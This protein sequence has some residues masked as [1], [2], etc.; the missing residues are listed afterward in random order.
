VVE[1]DPR[2][3]AVRPLD[4]VELL[5]LFLGEH[6][7]IGLLVILG[8]QVLALAALPGARSRSGSSGGGGGGEAGAD[9]FGG[10]GPVLALLRHRHASERRLELAQLGAAQLGASPQVVPRHLRACRRKLVQDAVGERSAAENGEGHY[11]RLELLR[12]SVADA[13]AGIIAASRDGRQHCSAHLCV[14]PQQVALVIGHAPLFTSAGNGC[15]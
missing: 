13:S 3:V 11:H 14:P 6:G 8:L 10:V 9:G 2:R 15:E 5:H 7:A 1:E 12:H 4:R